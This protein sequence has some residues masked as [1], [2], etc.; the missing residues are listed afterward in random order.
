MATTPPEASAPV[1]TTPVTA[2][3][4]TPVAPAGDLVSTQNGQLTG[5]AEFD[6]SAMT[7]QQL[8][9]VTLDLDKLVP[10][11]SSG[12][13]LMKAPEMVPSPNPDSTALVEAPL[14]LKV[15]AVETPVAE[16]LIEKHEAEE[17]EVIVDPKEE[18]PLEEPVVNGKP[19]QRRVRGET[20][21][22]DAAL[23]LYAAAQRKGQPITLAEAALEAGRIINREEKIEIVEVKSL[24]AA[25]AEREVLWKEHETAAAAFDRGAEAATLR[26]ITEKNEEIRDIKQDAVARRQQA[27][28]EAR[29]TYQTSMQQAATLYPDLAK[30]DS[31]ISKAK[32]E[33]HAALLASNDP[34]VKAADYPLDLARRAAKATSTAPVIPGKT[35]ISTKPVTIRS[36][37]PAKPAP[38]LLSATAR[39]TT[40]AKSITTGAVI[41]Q[42]GPRQLADLREAMNSHFGR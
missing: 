39:T 41:D 29:S 25:I 23:A 16:V 8:E 10:R 4:T 33:I 37:P 40:P 36:A 11:D 30:A 24:D 14:E 7:P 26:K 22:D 2:P 31:I 35:P 34:A 38:P 5:S 6:I 27:E 20:P 9:A 17:P 12:K 28:Y 13:A 3:V 1:E 19:P 18:V 21:E 15:P 42:M 32:D